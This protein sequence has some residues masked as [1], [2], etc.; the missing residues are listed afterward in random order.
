MGSWKA[1]RPRK[2]TVWEL[3]DL[4]TDISESKDLAKARPEILAKLKAYAQAAHTPAVEGTF[5]STVLHERD[6]AAKFGGKMPGKQTE[7]EGTTEPATK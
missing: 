6:R 5:A 1:V 7:P 3:Y 2:S 4:S